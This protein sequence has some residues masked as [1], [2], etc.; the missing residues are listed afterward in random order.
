M[1]ITSITRTISGG[2][3]SNISMTADVYSEDII[4]SANVLD[5]M[6]RLALDAIE[7]KLSEQRQKEL[8]EYEE[9]RKKAYEENMKEIGSS[10][11]K[12]EESDLPF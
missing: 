11:K 3:Y 8:K 6:C 9:L 12:E 10:I 1:K 4:V 7:K 2:N 5:T